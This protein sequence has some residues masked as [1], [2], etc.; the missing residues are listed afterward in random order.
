MLSVRDNWG[1]AK[2]SAHPDISVV[3]VVHNMAREAPRT[4]YSLSP[5]YQKHIDADAYEVIVVDNGS[6]PAFAASVIDGLAGNFRLIRIDPALPSP[7]HAV[8]VGIAAARGEIIGVMID[9]AR[10]VTPG[11]VYFSAHGVRLYNRAVV[12]SLG[13]YLGYDYQPWSILAGHDNSYEDALLES[14]NWQED[15]YRLFEIGTM[16]GPSE[17]GWF[18]PLDESGALFMSRQSW[19]LLGGMDEHFKQPGGGLVNLDTFC[20]ALEMP[21]AQ[22]VILLGE[23]TFHQAH[24]GI[25]SGTPA[26]Q[27]H[28]FADPWYKEYEALRG[29]PSP[30][31]RQDVARTYIGTLSRPALARFVR[32]SVHPLPRHAA[33]LGQSFDFKHWSSTPL[34]RPADARIAAAV[35][36]AYR[37]LESGRGSTAVAIARLLRQRAPN[38][39]TVLRL[40]SNNAGWRRYNEVAGPPA[41]HHLAMAEA[42]RQLGDGANALS[43]YREALKHSGDMPASSHAP[44]GG[45]NDLA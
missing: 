36:L 27:F 21:E 4:L 20:R 16:D 35:D 32:A 23:G 25:A 18:A 3:V 9:G 19:E 44:G 40:L 45:S 33:P 30:T 39:P 12:T 31:A 29:R 17:D 2:H 24:G 13:W 1:K 11:V 28:R 43:H 6:S 37:A 26:P 7:A 38:E 34:P 41:E 15:G 5:E 22:L 10:I 8:N 42:Y 14:S